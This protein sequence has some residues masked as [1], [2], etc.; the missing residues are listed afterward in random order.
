MRLGAFAILGGR[1]EAYLPKAG[2]GFGQRHA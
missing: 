2:T 1:A